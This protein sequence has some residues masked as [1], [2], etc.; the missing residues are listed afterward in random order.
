MTT[1]PSHSP[2]G[3][4]STA[5]TK[6]Q[7]AQ[8]NYTHVWVLPPTVKKPV[9]ISST[10]STVSN[11][12][13]GKPG[14]GSFHSSSGIEDDPSRQQQQKNRHGGRNPWGWKKGL[15]VEQ[16]KEQLVV[17]L[18][19][20]EQE[21][22]NE[23]DAY[24]YRQGRKNRTETTP[25]VL[26]F[27]AKAL[28]ESVL[29]TN[30]FDVD[31]ET[32]NILPPDDL[33]TL[34]HLN[35]P[36]VL[37]SL[38]ARY[39]R[40]IIYTNTGAV[41]LALNPFQS[42]RGLYG[43]AAMKSHWQ[44]AE[45]G[46]YSP[47]HVY[48]IADAA[49][50]SMRRQLE[51]GKRG[52][53]HQSI[54]VSGESGAGKTV[55]TKFVMKYLAALSQRSTIKEPQERAYRKAAAIRST[56]AVSPRPSSS[57]DDNLTSLTLLS[58]STSIEGQV[59]QSNPILESF[60][61]ARTVRNDNSSRFGKFIEIQFS[62]TGKLVGASIETYL[63]E[64]VRL[65]HQSPGERN[66]HIFYELLA[67]G[68][69]ARQLSHYF[70]ARTA[71]PED[72]KL[73]AS[74]TYDR[75][76]GV[77]DQETYKAL[78]HACVAMKFSNEDLHAVFCVTAA[79]L[80]A[81]NITLM[82][83]ED[84]EGEQCFLDHD[85]VHLTPVCQL[86]GI[87]VEDLELALCQQTL[88]V[89]RN[90]TVTKRLTLEKAIKGLEALLKAVYGALFQ[91]LVR[92]VNGSIAYKESEQEPPVASVRVLDIFGFESFH[93][94]SFEQLCI[95]YCNET[96]QQQFNAFVLKNEQAEYEREGIEW[97]FIAF[98]E[99][100]D[101]LDLIEKRGHGLLSLLDD[102]CRAPGPSDK[103]FFMQVFKKCTGLERLSISRQQEANQQF[104]IQHYAGL[105]EYTT[106]GFVEKNRDELSKE[107]TELVK[108]SSSP[109]VQ[110]LARIMEESTEEPCAPGSSSP[111]M[112]PRTLR[113]SDSSVGRATVGGQFR[114]QLRHLRTKID[115]TTPH[116]IRCLKPNDLLV[117]EHFDTSVVA[118]QLRCGGILEAV[119]VARAG[120]TQHYAH[121]DFVHRY[122]TLAWKEL[123][124]KEVRHQQQQQQSTTPSYLKSRTGAFRAASPN[125]FSS[126]TQNS[127]FRAT[128]PT[129]FSP[130][131]VNTAPASRK[132][133]NGTIQASSSFGG[134]PKTQCNDLIRILYRKIQ[135]QENEDQAAGGD[136][137]VD[138][139]GSIDSWDDSP[140]KAKSYAYKPAPRPSWTKS[141]FNRESTTPR[142]SV[143]NTKSPA[144]STPTANWK[145]GGPSSSDFAKVGIQMG[146]TKVFL[147]HKAFEI[148]ERMR[149][150]LRTK[151]AT[152]LNSI[153][154]MY[155]ARSAYIP[156]RDAFR[157]EMREKQM[158]FERAN[159]FKES[160]ESD[161]GDHEGHGYP[162][163]N[164]YNRGSVRGGDGEPPHFYNPSRLAAMFGGMANINSESLVDKWVESQVRNAIHN[165][166]PR[167]EWGK[168]APSNGS[169]KWVLSDGLWIRSAI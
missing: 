68:M 137:D 15:M 127:A 20:E 38:L 94:N 97:S 26:T 165:P 10:S 42:V 118:E 35:E 44:A 134:D 18:L 133:S 105:V 167:H 113:R 143:A 7:V 81:S 83:E 117:P 54:L 110:E 67:G 107:G 59:L 51:E 71:H 34:T 163:D 155:L 104:A 2:T 64:K 125:S 142:P 36:A 37:E 6:Q 11:S 151:A 124:K 40:D 80:H 61:N 147:R 91:Y 27:D 141:P 77:T 46:H 98:E 146:K 30:E 92:R 135:E 23:P 152:Q 130:S 89:G 116:Y 136:Y 72:F 109:F 58:G 13:H 90:Q 145:R 128:S 161:E 78:R 62:E 50:R 112:T 115:E 88:T 150:R 138:N 63:L 48:G 144:S 75:R 121:A 29:L 12:N 129:G 1:V 123:A 56:G 95:N 84:D 139:V 122:R 24:P 55:T 25:T 156:Y 100:Q 169:F 65:V 164:S 108:N 131:G 160:K 17:Q 70:I 159:E 4:S 31:P 168:A 76:D 69:D 66:Y 22:D 82:C 53:A 166:V 3:G 8:E 158:M 93:I 87:T 5:S 47:P 9:R 157:R 111:T 106:Y 60:G 19:E 114:R 140:A 52:R 21:Q 32:G 101:V 49:F 14:F 153:F 45:L 39:Q 57:H 162:S 79:L 96:L 102:Q 149:S 74:G 73:T 16:T 85:N 148:L 28:G 41:L 86:L 120:F 43:E 33:I 154:R 126:N 99:N 132:S 119:R 103:A